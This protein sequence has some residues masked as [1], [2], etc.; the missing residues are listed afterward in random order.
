MMMESGKRGGEEDEISVRIVK[1]GYSLLHSGLVGLMA[2]VPSI[3][4]LAVHQA[5]E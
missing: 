4:S 3:A 2:P 1:A 5:V